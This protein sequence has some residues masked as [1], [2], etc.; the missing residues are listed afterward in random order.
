MYALSDARRVLAAVDLHQG[1]AVSE[2]H[3]HLQ[4]GLRLKDTGQRILAFYLT[5]ME[6]RRLH[7]ASGHRSTI[8]FA[9]DRLG[10]DRRRAREL[11]AV[12][13]KLLGLPAIDGAFCEQKIGWSKL[14]L[15]TKVA[16]PE[17]EDAWLER[18]LACT[19][20]ELAREVLCVK[21]GRPPRKPGERRGLPEVRFPI[22]ASVGVLAHK[23]L[24]LAKQKLSDE[25]GRALDYAE[26]FEIMAELVLGTDDDGSVQGRT[27][28]DA[29]LYR[30]VLRPEEATNDGGLVAD[31]ELGPL[32]VEDGACIRCD[33]ECVHVEDDDDGSRSRPVDVDRTTPPALRRRVLARDGGHCRCCGSR[34]RIMVHHIRYRSHGGRTRV[35]N[36]ISLCVSC[37]ALVHAG[38]LILAGKRASDI[39]FLGSDGE[40]LEVSGEH[41]DP[42]ALAPL[43]RPRRSSEDDAPAKATPTPTSTPTPIMLDD[44]PDVIDGVWWQQHA[45]L[46]RFRGDQGLEF[47]EGGLPPVEATKATKVAGRPALSAKCRDEAFAGIVGQDALLQRL[48]ATVRGRRARGKW[49]PHT[50]FIGQAGT[51]KTTLASGIAE[52]SGARL[53]DT[54]G[55]FLRD[56]H[57][58]IRLLAMLR[59][60]DMLFLDEIH[61]VP[62]AILEVLYQALAEGH[63]TFT[64][65]AGARTRA[66]RLALPSFT[67]LAATTEEGSLPDALYSRF[68]LREFLGFY[69][70]EDLAALVTS[71]AHA[72]GFVLGSR[73]ASRL[74]ACARGTPREALRLLDRVLDE[75]T[76][77][78]RST[79]DRAAVDAALGRL[80]YDREGLEPAEQRYLA[81]LRQSPVPIPLG[82]L[83][84]MLGSSRR[85]LLRHLE[86][87]LFRRGLV[88]MTARGRVAVHPPRLLEA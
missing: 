77:D 3:S 40:P 66:V 6:D 58:V 17:H 22:R 44:V 11:I 64:L 7:Q 51:G 21:P 53:V 1:L 37:H 55:P 10:L 16:T 31:T 47:R 78:G 76:N 70:D 82:R 56:A 52:R 5:E 32:P 2:V 60:G 12:G 83:A 23:K 29:S 75:G 84:R 19:C 45:A 28:V 27:P 65:H 4:Q 24:D 87:F 13:H 25:H 68:G 26:C 67:L 74:A 63:L 35:W 62:S 36:L 71:T 50:L 9:G 79:L 43:S 14:L 54:A 18:A 88:R 69:A 39:R 81:I 15:L 59:E 86:P 80:G 8:Q 61:A 49:F 46:I 73:A 72:Q 20:R 85:T 33:G 34:R 57:S 30:I 41:V 48:D 38:L 42:R